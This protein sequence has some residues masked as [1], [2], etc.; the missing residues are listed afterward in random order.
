L[1]KGYS[2]ELL[3]KAGLILP[4][5]NNSYYDR[6]RRR[7][8]FPIFDVRSR[9]IAFGGRIIGEGEPKYL[10]SPETAVYTKARQLY[11]L[12]LSK[13]EIARKN[14]VIIVEGYL[15]F[16]IPY[17]AGVKNIV[18]SLGTALTIEQARLI[19]RYTTDCVIVYDSDTAGEKASLR[20]IEVLIKEGI[21]VKIASLPQGMDPDSMVREK[22]VGEFDK[23]VNESVEFFDYQANIFKKKYD[24]NTI[25]GKY[26]FAGEFLPTIAG[27]ENEVF[28]LCLQL[29]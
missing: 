11:G 4:G 21:S 17:Q 3:K 9:P 22:G 16:I 13:D 24:I 29:V 5:K 28:I 12:N 25:S 1:K 2:L 18:A 23:V 26:K 20:G 14:F 7:I 10:N 15:D 19:K 8:I 27:I 6:F